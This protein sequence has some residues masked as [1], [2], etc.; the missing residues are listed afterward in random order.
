[1]ARTRERPEHHYY[2]EATPRSQRVHKFPAPGIHQGIG[3]QERRLEH[4]ELLIGER[5]VSADRFYCDRQ[6][7]SVK[8]ADGNR[9]THQDGDSPPHTGFLPLKLA[10]PK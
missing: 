4:R 3:E 8:V 10:P 7:L 2:S 9:R 6:R 5:N 1:M